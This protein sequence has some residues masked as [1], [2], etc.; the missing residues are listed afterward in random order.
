MFLDD[1]RSHPGS[2]Y[3]RRLQNQDQM[4]DITR[5]NERNGRIFQNITYL[6][7]GDE[8]GKAGQR[9]QDHINEGHGPP[10]T[11]TTRKRGMQRQTRVIFKPST[12]KNPLHVSAWMVSFQLGCAGDTY[13]FFLPMRNFFFTKTMYF[14]GTHTSRAV[15]VI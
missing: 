5:L 13:H 6:R 15:E 9:S 7:A 11:E 10:D 4:G 3:S 12:V 2:I 14:R 1:E 8:K